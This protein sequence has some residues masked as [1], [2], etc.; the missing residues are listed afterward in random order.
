MGTMT[1]RLFTIG[2]VVRVRPLENRRKA[3]MHSGYHAIITDFRGEDG[4]DCE[5]WIDTDHERV[6]SFLGRRQSVSF[7]GWFR[8]SDLDQMPDGE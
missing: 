1:A 3:M 6:S 2:D 4:P 5:A 8:L 7:R